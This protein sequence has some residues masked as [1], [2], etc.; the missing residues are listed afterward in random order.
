MVRCS[1]DE[2][3]GWPVGGLVCWW[4]DGLV[5]WCVGPLVGWWVRWWVRWSVGPL[6][7]SSEF[8]LSRA[9]R[10]VSC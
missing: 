9:T 6:V 10:T 4:V 8:M 7:G 5:R 2:L 1:V 3:M